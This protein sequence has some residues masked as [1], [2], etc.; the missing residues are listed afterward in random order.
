MAGDGMPRSSFLLTG[1]II[2]RLIRGLSIL[3][4]FYARAGAALPV[5][6][7][8]PGALLPHDYRAM[9][10]ARRTHKL[11]GFLNNLAMAAG[12]LPVVLNG[13]GS[14]SIDAAKA[15]RSL[16]P[17]NSPVSALTTEFK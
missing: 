8:V 15:R 12:A 5:A 7:V 14:W 10:A 11:I 17:D 13:A 3:F 1:S 6:F 4:G 2:R 9:P 16:L